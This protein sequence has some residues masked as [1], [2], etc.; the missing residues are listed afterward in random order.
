MKYYLFTI[1]FVG[2]TFDAY[3]QENTAWNWFFGNHAGVNFNTGIPITTGQG[4]VNNYEGCSTIGDMN[5]NLLF[6]TDGTTVFNRNHQI[7]SNGSGLLGSISSTQSSVIVPKPGSDHLFHIFTVDE[8]ESHLVDGLCY[9]VVDINDDG[10]LGAVTV[11]NVLLE[12]PV[13]EKLTSV[14]HQNNIDVWVIAHRWN[15]NE[16]VAY[17]VTEDGIETTPVVSAVGS[18]HQGGTSTNS[19]SNG[20]TNSMGYL[21]ASISGLKIAA[22]IFRQNKVELFSF[23]RGTG[24]LSNPYSSNSNL[25]D[26]YGIEFS[27][28]EEFLYVSTVKS[29]SAPSTIYQFDIT[30]A[31]AT[32]V[33]V[34]QLGSSGSGVDGFGALQLGPNGKIY[35]MEAYSQYLAVINQ[36]NNLATACDFEMNGVFL[37]GNFGVRGLPTLFYYKGFSFFT[38]S[39]IDS[40]LCYGDSLFA[41]DQYHTVAGTFYDTLT[42]NLGW[43]SILNINLSFYEQNTISISLFENILYASSEANYQWYFNNQL[44]NGANSQSFTPNQTGWYYVT[45]ENENNCITRSDSIYFTSTS[46]DKF[47]SNE[48]AISPNPTNGLFTIMKA[49]KGKVEI[50]SMTGQLVYERIIEDTQSE[51]DIQNLEPGVYKLLLKGHSEVKAKMIIKL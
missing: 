26:V 33:I 41:G 36:P 6:Y 44:I 10:G 42:T 27:P 48:L 38:G 29:N 15:S 19:Q 46:I 5:G 30:Q 23:N 22:A 25:Y 40:T 1:L 51:I 18:I 20:Y 12:T 50:F 2:F 28:N 3:C 4:Q 37:N 11:K 9:S 7:M 16:F 35:V 8:A 24:Q 45:S 34:Q 47:V 49:K 39:E 14:M 21:K 31:G 32:P 43:D 17:L 13:A